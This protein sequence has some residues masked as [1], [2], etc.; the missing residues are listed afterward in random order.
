M[1]APALVRHPR[2]IATPHIGGLTQPAI[3]HQALETVA[4]LAALLKG[5]MP[6][7]PSIRRMPIAGGAGATGS[8][9]KEPHDDLALALAR[10]LRQ[11]HARLRG[12][13]SARADGDVQAAARAGA[14]YR[15]VQREL[16]LART[17]VIQP[18][19]YGFDNRCTLAALAALGP[20]ARAIVVVAA[21]RAP[22]EL[23]VAARRSARAAS[24]T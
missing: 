6:A 9:T 24:A 22:A 21:G 19:G 5:E 15:A 12:R 10:C 4:Q 7:A 2:V 23:A 11:P 8:A 18:T 3:E 13:L 17:V 14:A 16:G 20:E 1:P